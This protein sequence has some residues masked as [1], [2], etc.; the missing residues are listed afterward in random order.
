MQYTTLTAMMNTSAW[1]STPIVFKDDDRDEDVCPSDGPSD[2]AWNTNQSTNKIAD[3]D[4]STQ[5]SRNV[6]IIR[7]ML[8]P[9]NTY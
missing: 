5:M 9:N 4:A 2:R 8:S 3:K 7:R 6:A 1:E